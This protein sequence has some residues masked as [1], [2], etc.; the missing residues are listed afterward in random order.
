MYSSASRASAGRYS[1]FSAFGL[2]P[3]ALMGLDVADFLRRAQSMV[4]NCAA[5][6]P[7]AANPGIELGAI[8]GSMAVAGA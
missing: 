3:A 5:D 2:V 1:A 4:V 7:P 8:L 6:V